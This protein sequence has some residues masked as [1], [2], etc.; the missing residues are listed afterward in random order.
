MKFKVHQHRKLG[1]EENKGKTS[2]DVISKIGLEEQGL[3]MGIGEK[4]FFFVENLWKKSS[5]KHIFYKSCHPESHKE[6]THVEKSHF[7]FKKTREFFS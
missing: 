1:K 4:K 3:G 5:M 2:K 7:T 6:V